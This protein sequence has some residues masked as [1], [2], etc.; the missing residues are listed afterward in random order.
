MMKNILVSLGIE[1]LKIRRSTIFRITIAASIFTSLMLAFMMVLVQNPGVLPPGILK[2]KVELAALRAD[3]PAYLS[4]IE[5][6]GG[7]LGIILFGFVVSWVFGREYSDRTVKDI[8]VL[9]VG[10]SA[11]VCSKLIA[12]ALWCLLLGVIMF[13]LG[14]ALGACIQLPLWSPLLLPEFSRVYFVTTLLSI[15]LLPPLAFVASA[16][17]GYLPAIG[18]MLLCMGLANL[19]GNIGLGAWFPWTIP[20]LYTQAIGTIGDGLPAASYMILGLTSLAGIAGTV[21]YWNY[22]DQNR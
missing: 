10:R 14:L 7:A 19:F 22:A 1:L 17:R 15:A 4:F 16:G 9:P 20:M 5:M 6:A 11:I 18:F 2:T 3:W 8:L 21:V 13:L 12:S